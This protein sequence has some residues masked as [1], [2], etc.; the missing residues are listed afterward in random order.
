M[1]FFHVLLLS[2]FIPASVVVLGFLLLIFSDVI[3]FILSH[4]RK[5]GVKK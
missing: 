5:G 4:F 1:Y 3:N 2:L